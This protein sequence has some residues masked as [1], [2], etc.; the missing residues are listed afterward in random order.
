MGIKVGQ[1]RRGGSCGTPQ[2]YQAAALGSALSWSP[3]AT[4]F[5][6]YKVG[7]QKPWHKGVEMFL[8]KL[9]P[10]TAANGWDLHEISIFSGCKRRKHLFFLKKKMPWCKSRNPAIHPHLSCLPSPS[11][12][13]FSSLPFPC[14]PLRG[15]FLPA[16]GS[17]KYCGGVQA[18]LPVALPL[19][20]GMQP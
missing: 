20:A 18:V 12:S 3:P 5:P 8:G 15:L 7:T 10:A 4:K 17:L 6:E 14:E 9:D 11:F 19:M 1:H 13:N 16:E 2:F